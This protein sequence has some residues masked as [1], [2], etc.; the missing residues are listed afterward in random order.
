MFRNILPVALLVVL[1]A[2]CGGAPEKAAVPAQGTPVAVGTLV[3]Q[4]IEWPATLEAVGT[5]RARTSATI[6]SKVMG[7]VREV[8]VQA[9][10]YNQCG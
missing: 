10:K 8:R 3:V 4:P 6:A 1:L 7:H 5:V 9:G 2:G